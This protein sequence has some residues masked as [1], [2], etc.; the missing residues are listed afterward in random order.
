M[1]RVNRDNSKSNAIW[2]GTYE[3][4]GTT[5]PVVFKKFSAT[6]SGLVTGAG[7]DEIGRFTIKGKVDA[8]GVATFAKQ[9]IG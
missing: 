2:K 8:K 9:Y 4:D 5:Y 6:R 1:V 3:Y 7:S